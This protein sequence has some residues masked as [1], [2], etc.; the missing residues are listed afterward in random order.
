LFSAFLLLLKQVLSWIDVILLLLKQDPDLN[1]LLKLILENSVVL[2]LLKQDLT[3]M[4]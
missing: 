4:K 3:Y 1:E 2:L